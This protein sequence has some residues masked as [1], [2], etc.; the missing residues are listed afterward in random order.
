MIRGFFLFIF[1]FHAIVQISH[2]SQEK[3]LAKALKLELYKDKQ[4]HNLLHYRPTLLG[5][6]KSQADGQAFFNDPAGSSDPQA[7]LIATIRAFY[8]SPVHKNINRHPSCRFP[9]R[10]LFFKRKLGTDFNPQELNCEG[11]FKFRKKMAAAS[12]S[13]VFSS[14]YLNRPASAFG[15]TLL[16]F[17]KNKAN[18]KTRAYE[19]L[20]YSVN[21]SATITTNNALLYA[22][23]GFAGWYNGEYAAIPY[24]YK[25]REY[26]D[27][28]SRDLW[29]YELNLTAPEIEIIIAHVW[30]MSSTYF[31]YFYFTENC[32]YHMLALLDVARPAWNLQERMAYLIIPVDTLHVV[33]KTPG[34]VKSI[35]FRPSQRRKLKARLATLNKTETHSF[36]KFI[37]NFETDKVDHQLSD[38][39]KIK[40]LDAGIDYL[41]FVYAKEV[42]SEKTQQLG[43]KRK[44]LIARSKIPK[45][46]IDLNIQLPK[47]EFPH[48][49]H[50][51]RRI[52]LGAGRT[53]QLQEFYSFQYRFALHDFLDPPNGQN[54]DARMEMGD[55]RFRYSPNKLS[56][57]FVLE[58]FAF[59]DVVSLSPL[60]RLFSDMSWRAYFGAKS[61]NDTSCN[62]CLAPL[63]QLGSGFS[64]RFSFIHYYLF[65]TSDFAL[66]KRLGHRG[67]RLGLGPELAILVSPRNDFN[68]KI[69]ADYKVFTLS[70]VKKLY[71]YGTEWRWQYIKNN[72]FNILYA[73]KNHD[74]E[75]SSAFYYYF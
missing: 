41:D 10:L 3:A 62:E 22:I 36:L 46:S 59:V 7:E 45:K 31:K 28:E 25:I 11:F 71:T 50:Y 56:K 9:A 20:D 24:F 6:V 19:L 39:S 68:F 18:E 69:F 57:K 44:I 65:L 43:W 29:S 42:L 58:E 26:N 70:R 32:S 35:S 2:A 12:L 33:A 49:G 34:L 37:E 21:Y 75:W 51:T 1:L 66:S 40:I 5:G 15:H 60:Q 17:N 16:R 67:M 74:W 52:G 14:Y 47:N 54:P 38:Q 48:L 63:A 72:S 23:G 61:L 13:L 4:W 27:Y 55:F 8:Q 73:K 64:Q 53:K 30:E